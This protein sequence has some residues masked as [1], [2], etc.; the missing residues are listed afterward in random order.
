MKM[1][2]RKQLKLQ[3]YMTRNWIWHRNVLN[4][5]QSHIQLGTIASQCY[6]NTQ[7]QIFKQSCHCANKHWPLIVETFIVGTIGDP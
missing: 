5:I 3:N 6:A 2:K 4:A 7:N 1:T